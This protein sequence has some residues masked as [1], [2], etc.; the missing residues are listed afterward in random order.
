MVIRVS[1]GLVPVVGEPERTIG[2]CQWCGRVSDGLAVVDGWEV[3]EACADAARHPCKQASQSRDDS[4]GRVFA[5]GSMPRPSGAAGAV[6][7]GDRSD[8]RGGL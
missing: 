2:A 6:L 8:P 3:C 1:P 4:P 5:L 7:D